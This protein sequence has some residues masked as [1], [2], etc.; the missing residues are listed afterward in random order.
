[1]PEI[2]FVFAH[3]SLLT[4]LPVVLILTIDKIGEI[5]SK[6][7]LNN[8]HQG[9]LNFRWRNLVMAWTRTSVLV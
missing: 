4:C 5:I 6:H 9:L 1:M 8:I 3:I 7:G 2:E